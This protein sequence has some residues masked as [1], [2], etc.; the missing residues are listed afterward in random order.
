MPEKSG[1]ELL[2][3]IVEDFPNIPVI[4]TTGQEEIDTVVRCIKAGAFDYL[5][6]PIHY[7]RL[8]VAANAAME[9]YSLRTKV[10][11]L[12]QKVSADA[13]LVPA[14]F[15]E[16]ITCHPAMLDLFKYVEAISKTP[17]PVLVLGE[18]GTGKELFANAI[19]KASGRQ[20]KLVT[21]NVAGLDDNL[22]SDTLF[23]HVKGAF[24]G[25]DYSREGMVAQAQGGTFYPCL[26]YSDL[27]FWN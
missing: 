7:S 9:I 5:V 1:A 19:H 12:D 16:I 17:F 20:G 14:C 24:S 13:C 21:V 6:K 27:P 4:I 18:T 26:R 3:E 25:A 23:G 2:E 22:F 10:N 15:D 11:E 8:I